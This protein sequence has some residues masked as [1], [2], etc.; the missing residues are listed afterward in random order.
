[1]TTADLDRWVVRLNPSPKP[2]VRLFC[3]PYAGGT[4]SIFTSWPDGLPSTVEVCA[5]ELP[6]RITR[7]QETPLT[8]LSLLIQVIARAILPYLDRPFA[9]FGHSMGAITNFELA[10]YLQ[11]RYGLSPIYLFVSGRRAP[12][13]PDPDPPIHALPEPEFM[14][15]LR[16]FN[17]TPHEILDHDELMQLLIP[18]LRADFELC[19]S[20]VYSSGPRLNCPISAF[21]GE[22]DPKVSQEYLDAWREQTNA[23]FNIKMFPG[24]HFFLHTAQSSLLQ[25]LSEDLNNVMMRATKCL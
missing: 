3:L 19:E 17:G 10:R 4:S 22:N 9:L 15:E 13:I 25:A 7:I 6:G 1:M 21:G 11:T 16:H 18:V 2:D 23:S 20:Y 8:R 12:Q 14:E 24:D 5:L